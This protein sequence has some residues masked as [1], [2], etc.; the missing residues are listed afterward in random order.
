MEG[1]INTEEAGRR[2]EATSQA[3]TQTHEHITSSSQ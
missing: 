1:I 3:E 2:K